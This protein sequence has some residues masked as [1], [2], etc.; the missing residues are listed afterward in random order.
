M[1]LPFLCSSYSFWHRNWLPFTLQ[2]IS[3]YLKICDAYYSC[4]NVDDGYEKLKLEYETLQK[5]FREIQGL[6][7]SMTGKLDEYAHKEVS[8]KKERSHL[9]GKVKASSTELG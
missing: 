6:Q 4:E 1:V 3:D 8:W 7:L 5:S 9:F 2:F